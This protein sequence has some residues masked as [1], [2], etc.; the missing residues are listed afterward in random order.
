M[1]AG[2][3]KLVLGGKQAILQTPQIIISRTKKGQILIWPRKKTQKL[4]RL[5]D[6]DT[7]KDEYSNNNS[8]T[9]KNFLY[10]VSELRPTEHL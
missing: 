5:K 2:M 8:M 4:K 10:I 6:K 3:R 1:P 9:S 7:G